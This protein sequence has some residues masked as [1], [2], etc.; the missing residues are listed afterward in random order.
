MPAAEQRGRQTTSKRGTRSTPRPRQ[1]TRATGDGAAAVE[2]QPLERFFPGCF[3]ILL[4]AITTVIPQIFEAIRAENRARPESARQPD[5]VIDRSLGELLALIGPLLS[6]ILPVMIERIDETGR[7]RE[8]S[9]E[10]YLDDEALERFLPALLGA[11]LPTLITALPP[12]LQGVS[13][14]LGGLF[15]G[16][17]DVESPPPRVADS[18][19]SARFLG[20]ILQA[21]VPA[22]VANLP[23]LF[24]LI[25]GQGSRASRDVG[26]SWQ[27][28][29]ETNR[30]WDNDTVSVWQDPIDDQD[31][32]EIALQLA[33]HKSWWKGIQIQDDNGSFVAEVGVEG[34]RKYASTR[35]DARTLLDPGGYLLFMK[36]KLFGIH[37]G[38]YR[39]ATGGLDELRGQ[40]STFYWY[41]D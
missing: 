9:G 37:T 8:A 3:E 4:P 25:T 1:A 12:A 13:G 29:T 16:G 28:F 22:V 17:R 23:Q 27:D 38:M 21:V 26:V 7:E 41:A 40:R 39:L 10:E 14:M 2:E 31:A 36:A 18:E 33:P 19:V 32:V 24:E 5:E 15:G 30:L 11:M 20:P 34:N 6:Q 35:V